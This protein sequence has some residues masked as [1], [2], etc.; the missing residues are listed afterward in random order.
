MHEGKTP[1]Y[2]RKKHPVADMLKRSRYAWQGP[3]NILWGDPDS[4]YFGW[5]ILYLEVTNIMKNQI[6][7][8]IAY[9][10][11]YAEDHIKAV[12]RAVYWNGDYEKKQARA[13]D[14]V[15]IPKVAARFVEIDRSQVQDWLSQF[16][17][18]RYGI[19][20]NCSYD[21]D[22]PVRRLRAEM[23]YASCAFEF[24]WESNAQPFKELNERWDRV[25][26]SMG[27]ALEKSPVLSS[28]DEDFKAY[29]PS[30]EYGLNSY[31]LE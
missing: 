27:Q 2:R 24:L 26:S 5:P 7:T 21:E 1:R 22:V 20:T 6:N 12:L 11:L 3:D 17:G 9:G 4:P 29:E 8:R 10:H 19:D 30:F 25:W 23:D 28:F 13:K 14:Q 16:D 31:P 15:H 18:L